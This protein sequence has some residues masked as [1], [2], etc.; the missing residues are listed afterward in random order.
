VLYHRSVAFFRKN[1]TLSLD[2]LCASA[3]SWTRHSPASCTLENTHTP[4]KQGTDS[5][6]CERHVLTR[7]AVSRGGVW[8]RRDVREAHTALHVLRRQPCRPAL[9]EPVLGARAK[10]ARR[11]ESRCRAHEERYAEINALHRVA[12]QRGFARAERHFSDGREV[13]LPPREQSNVCVCVC[14]CVC[15]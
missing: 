13:D 7:R 10:G 6:R 4:G 14:V 8:G 3:V 15:V 2:C 12:L 1:S 11:E 5:S 9:Q